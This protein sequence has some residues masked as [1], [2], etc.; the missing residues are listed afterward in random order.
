MSNPT[1]WSF[2]FGICKGQIGWTCKIARQ[3]SRKITYFLSLLFFH[4]FTFLL[5]KKKIQGQI[6]AYRLRLCAANDTVRN[7]R[8]TLAPVADLLLN[9][10]TVRVMHSESLP[11]CTSAFSTVAPSLRPGI[12]RY[13]P[14]RLSW[15]VTGMHRRG[16][17]QRSAPVYFE[18]KY[19]RNI[20]LSMNY[21]NSTLLLLHISQQ[22]E[23]HIYCRRIYIR[24]RL[25]LR[26]L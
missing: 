2:I 7:F 11:P 4:L 19:M 13:F 5:L 25:G 3:S 15:S 26:A 10:G 24:L 22:L 6:L 8:T 12:T 17:F 21:T 14:E 9:L 18:M 23:S 1:N 20:G 16:W